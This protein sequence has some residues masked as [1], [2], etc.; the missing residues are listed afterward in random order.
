MAYA[1][2]TTVADVKGWLRNTSSS[3]DALLGAL[4]DSLSAQ[5]GLYLGRDNLG[6]IETYAER[7]RVPRCGSVVEPARLMLRHY[8]VTALTGVSASGQAMAIVD[9]LDPGAGAG[10]YLESDNRT[11][12]FSGAIVPGNGLGVMLVSYQAGYPKPPPGISQAMNQWVGEV[13]KAQGWIGKTSES[14][15][16]QTVSFEQGRQWNMSKRTKEM[17]E[18]YRDRIPASP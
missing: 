1:K 14:L 10:A 11:V 4:I 18:P 16:G 13:V 8:P 3:D 2:L 15:A 7:Y 12:A 17:F 6:S 9:P 5:A